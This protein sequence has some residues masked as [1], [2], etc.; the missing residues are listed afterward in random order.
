MTYVLIPGAGDVAPSRDPV[1][2]RLRDRGHDVVAV[3]LPAGDD[4]AGLAQYTDTVVDA[5]GDRGD[6]VVVAHSLGGLTAPL[7]CD[8]LPVDLLVLVT[9]VIPAPGE[10]GRDWWANTGH[11]E[12]YRLHNADRGESDIEIFLADAEPEDAEAA[13]ALSGDQSSRPLEDPWPLDAWPD[14][15]TRFVLCRDDHF[16]PAEWMRGVVRERL[17]I[18]PDEIDAGH[19]PYVS[20][21]GELV[22]K[23]EELRA[24]ATRR[25]RSAAGP[26]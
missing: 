21:P 26:A 5:V 18:E 8:R 12:A 1:S 10:T 24:G 25:S 6:L 7:V 20:R 3:D 11:P 16:F 14:V 9:A 2:R 22:A 23:L 4:S 13:L 17:G 19:C 15:E